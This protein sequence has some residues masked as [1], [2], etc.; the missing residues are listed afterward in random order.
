M[1]YQAFDSQLFT[2]N[3][4]RLISQLLPQSVCIVGSNDTMPTNADGTMGFRQNSDLFYLTG[5][6]QENTILVLAPN[7]PDPTLREVLFIEQTSDLIAIW[8]G[9]KYTKEHAQSASGIKTIFWNS[10]FEA[11]SRQIIFASQ[12]IY[13]NSNEHLRNGSEVETKT[14]RLNKQIIA[15]FP[16]HQ[17]QR[18]APIMHQLRMIKQ[19]DELEA[20][21]TAIDITAKGFDRLLKFVKPGVM[22]Y[23]IEAELI[24]EFIRNKS[25]GFAYTPIIASGASACVLHYIENNRP[26]QDGDLLLLD[27][28][29][30]YGNYNADMT[31]AIPVNGRFSP[32]Q[33]Q[34]YKAVLATN[35]FAQD[36]IKPGVLWDTLQKEVELF[37]ESQCIDLGLFSRADVEK[38]NPAS[39]LYKKYF[40]HGNSHHLGLDVHDVWD[41]YTPFSAGMVLTNEPGIYIKEEGIGI[42]LENNVL[43]TSSG[44]INLMDK[45]PI[46]IE[47]IEEIMNA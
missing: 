29:A 2:S 3:R 43:V 44:S 31:R 38:Q 25:R 15:N 19:S 18:L 9:Y 4:K 21:Q 39:P 34:I 10:Q 16:L 5:I 28:A 1:K 30:E 27:V 14:D 35:K 42:R 6:D 46:E 23:E 40:M 41:K 45:I 13:L 7:H 22:E 36:F 37:V 17:V 32:R 26:C 8:E 20:L 33:K 47:E 12:A 24:H 11:I